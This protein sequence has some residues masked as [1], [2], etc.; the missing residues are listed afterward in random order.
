MNMTIRL[1]IDVDGPRYQAEAGFL[2]ELRWFQETPRVVQQA[3]A[4]QPIDF[5]GVPVRFG[6]YEILKDA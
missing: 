3:R 2:R 5:G 4:R 6:D 1:C